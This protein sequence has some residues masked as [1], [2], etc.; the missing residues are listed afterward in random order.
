MSRP[1][2]DAQPAGPGC[3]SPRRLPPDLQASHL[4]HT[5]SACLT[6]AWTSRDMHSRPVTNAFPLVQLSAGTLRGHHKLD[7]VTHTTRTSCSIRSADRA[8]VNRAEALALLE[9]STTTREQAKGYAGRG[10]ERVR[11]G[12]W[13]ARER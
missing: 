12:V 9:R 1:D 10:R 3:A 2:G 7:R 5:M 13:A 4:Q 8:K 6:A 11:A